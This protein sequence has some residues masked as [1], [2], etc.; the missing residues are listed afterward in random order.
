MGHIKYMP[1]FS[2]KGL[3]NLSD[4]KIKFLIA[5][6]FVGQIET[7]LESF[8][9]APHIIPKRILNKIR[10]SESAEISFSVEQ[11]EF[12]EP[13]EKLDKIKLIQWMYENGYFSL[14]AA[15]MLSNEIEKGTFDL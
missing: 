15:D 13:V 11:S 10:N 4:V 14:I 5:G 8:D 7:S 6:R 1:R 9:A 2:A 12:F 3:Q